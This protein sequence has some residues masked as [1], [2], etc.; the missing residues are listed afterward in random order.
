MSPN[1]IK[2]IKPS[3]RGHVYLV[4]DPSDPAGEAWVPASK[5]PRARD[6]S[7]V[8]FHRAHP[9]KPVP[10]GIAGLVFPITGVAAEPPSPVDGEAPTSPSLANPDSDTS[11]EDQLDRFSL[12]P[13]DGRDLDRFSLGPDDGR[14]PDRV[15]L[16]P[17]DG[18]DLDRFSL[19]PDNGNEDPSPPSSEMAV[20]S[21]RGISYEELLLQGIGEREDDSIFAPGLPLPSPSLPSPQRTSGAWP[22]SPTT[23][24]IPSPSIGGA[25]LSTF[26]PPSVSS[27]ET[28]DI[29]DFGAAVSAEEED[30]VGYPAIA[31]RADVGG[32]T[33]DAAEQTRRQQR[34]V[35]AR[36]PWPAAPEYVPLPVLPPLCGAVRR[37]LGMMRLREG[38]GG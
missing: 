33:T 13:D 5:L 19:S 15:C 17:D 10:D 4:A 23:P 28:T 31:E 7:R 2:D 14:E 35:D 20:E 16:G 29:R 37:R 11:L 1:T 6:R 34:R 25:D 32:N 30:E 27:C 26:L 8:A 12:G 9:D 24:V 3:G 22:S 38:G 18:R 36:L 21:R